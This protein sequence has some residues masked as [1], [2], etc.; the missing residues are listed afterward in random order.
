MHLDPYSGTGKSEIVL[1]RPTLFSLLADIPSVPE[2]TR[3]WIRVVIWMVD[4][5]TGANL[6]RLGIRSIKIPAHS[7]SDPS[8]Q[9]KGDLMEDMGKLCHHGAVNPP[10]IVFVG[11]ATS[12]LTSA[13]ASPNFP[14][15]EG[16]LGGS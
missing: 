11:K 8:N 7:L 9:L 10:G 1:R 14:I 12:Y 6:Q 13:Q 15:E 4:Q 2:A 3:L 5:F 16:V